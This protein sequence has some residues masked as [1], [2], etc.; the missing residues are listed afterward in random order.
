MAQL[1]RLRAEL[2]LAAATRRQEDLAHR[3]LRGQ[4]H[5]VGSCRPGADDGFALLA[6]PFLDHLAD[7]WCPLSELAPDRRDIDAA[8]RVL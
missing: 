7:L 8:S 1:D 3:N 4:A 2:E 5:R 6:G